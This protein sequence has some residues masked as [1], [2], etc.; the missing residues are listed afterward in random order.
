MSDE[1]KSFVVY[2]FTC[3]SSSYSYLGEICRHFTTRIEELIKKDNKTYNFKHLHST[4]QLPQNALTRIIF[5]LLK[6]LIKL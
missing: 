2:K 1:L 5:F 4:S 3:A 6:Q